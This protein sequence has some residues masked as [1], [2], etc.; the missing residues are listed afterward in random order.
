M[1]YGLDCSSKA[2]SF[3]TVKAKSFIKFCRLQILFVDGYGICLKVVNGV[4]YKFFIY[5]LLAIFVFNV[6]KCD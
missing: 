1:G 4:I 5:I 2:G 3:I 6:D